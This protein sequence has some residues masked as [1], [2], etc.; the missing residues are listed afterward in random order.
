MSM[1]GGFNLPAGMDQVG[2]GFGSG[3]RI[4]VA[5]SA[6]PVP[7]LL[8]NVTPAVL[9]RLLSEHATHSCRMGTVHTAGHDR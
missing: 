3:N 5:S 6:G 2:H 4:S 9:S 7:P 1:E 8:T